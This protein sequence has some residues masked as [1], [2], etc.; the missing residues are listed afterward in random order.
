[1]FLFLLM[2]IRAGW[3]WWRQ[4]KKEAQFYGP[5]TENVSKTRTYFV[6]YYLLSCVYSVGLSIEIEM[7]I[8][9]TVNALS[10]RAILLF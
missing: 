10:V 2:K 7:L 9:M 8:L 1:M 6:N 5:D 3:I 4:D